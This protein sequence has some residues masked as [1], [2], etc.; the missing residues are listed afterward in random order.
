LKFAAVGSIGVIVNLAAMALLLHSTRWSGW[1]ASAV[2]GILANIHNYVLN[3]TWS[4]AD[5]AHRGS[6][7]LKGYLS[8]LSMSALGL[9]ITTAAYAG[10]TWSLTK[11]SILQNGTQGFAS[12]P[13][14][15]CQLIGVALGVY[16]NYELNKFI[17]W[18][19][20]S[21]SG[22]R[23]SKQPSRSVLL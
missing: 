7:L 11:L 13:R 19:K 8:Y 14:L 21:R 1:Q 2:A 4:F 20:L 5:R 6:R 17:T 9:S 23:V 3:N 16:F 18:P 15:L 22:A 12:L 10:L